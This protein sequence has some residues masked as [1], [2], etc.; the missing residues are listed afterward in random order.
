MCIRRFWREATE[1]VPGHDR[2]QTE[3]KMATD[4]HPPT[5]R[6]STQSSEREEVI[7]V[8]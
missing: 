4:F 5:I 1:S 7:V 3:Q 6:R 2:E 8:P